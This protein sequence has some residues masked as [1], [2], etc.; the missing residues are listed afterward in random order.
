VIAIL[1]DSTLWGRDFPSLLAYMRAWQDAGERIVLV[2][3]DTAMGGARRLTPTEAA[4]A[5]DVFRSALQ[6]PPLAVRTLALPR[7]TEAGRHSPPF[8]PA[9]VTLFDDGSLRLG[10][11]GQGLQLLARPLTVDHLRRR[12][13]S[14]EAVRRE[15]IQSDREGRPTVLTLYVY[16]GGAVIFAESDLAPR[17]GAIDRAF[18]DT[19]VITAAVFK[20]GQ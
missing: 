20:E 6:R 15:L 4:R 5:V 9:V 13:G 2:F 1:A 14:P 3:A 10:A 8:Q 18:L 7:V 11:V 17:P 12:L 16:A 19:D